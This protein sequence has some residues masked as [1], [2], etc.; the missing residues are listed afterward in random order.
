MQNVFSHGSSGT[1]RAVSEREMNQM[2]RLESFPP[3]TT[4]PIV[5]RPR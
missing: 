4:H 5:H 2:M 1:T 3:S